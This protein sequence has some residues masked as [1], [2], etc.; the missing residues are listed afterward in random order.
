MSI[1][2][3]VY[4]HIVLEYA[5]QT[6]SRASSRHTALGASQNISHRHGLYCM[7]VRIYMCKCVQS[8][9]G[10]PTWLKS[11][12]VDSKVETWDLKFLPMDPL[13]YP[14][15][16]LGLPGCRESVYI[17]LNSGSTDMAMCCAL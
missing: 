10:E 6:V 5:G 4:A 11:G 13:M 14:M 17:K 9:G 16:E 15:A 1:G 8:D 7:H 3:C 2:T 12:S